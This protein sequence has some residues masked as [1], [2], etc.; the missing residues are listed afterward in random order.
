MYEQ[1]VAKLD[2]NVEKHCYQLCQKN[3]HEANPDKEI[4]TR[5][6]HEKIKE[7]LKFSKMLHNEQLKI[8]D[9]RIAD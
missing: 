4:F 2:A 6:D 7:S 9:V 8:K 1:Q 3:M 5:L